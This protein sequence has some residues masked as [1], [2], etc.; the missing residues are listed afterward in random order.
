MTNIITIPDCILQFLF[1]QDWLL[2]SGSLIFLFA[3]FLF[4]KFVLFYGDEKQEEKHISIVKETPKA[5]EEKPIV[6]QQ[7]TEEAVVEKKEKDDNNTNTINDDDHQ[8]QPPNK[9]KEKAKHQ[10]APVLTAT[11]EEAVF[12][13]IKNDEVN[14]NNKQQVAMIYGP[15]IEQKASGAAF[16]SYKLM[17]K[18]LSIKSELKMILVVRR[19]LK[20]TES[21]AASWGSTCACEVV[22]HIRSSCREPWL[23]WLR[24]WNSVGVAKVAVRLD[25]FEAIKTVIENSQNVHKGVSLPI[26]GLVMSEKK[27][28]SNDDD[29]KDDGSN[30]KKKVVAPPKKPAP[31][32]ITKMEFS[33]LCSRDLEAKVKATT[34]ASSAA[35]TVGDGDDDA[36][37]QESNSSSVNK[38]DFDIPVV[39]IGPCPSDLHV[40][41]TDLLK[42]Y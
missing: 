12:S 24:A 17:M 34:A 38:R 18:S 36:T 15:N 40:G 4:G 3:G 21:L 7:P 32:D 20:P 39:A 23:S 5:E 10:T 29:N 25:S 35:T 8:Q 2:F 22:Q 27:K 11:S 30:K 13:L 42:L 1:T 33:V 9:Q 41:V 26:A 16:Q 6:A 19:D 37:Q 14:E 31:L 28:K